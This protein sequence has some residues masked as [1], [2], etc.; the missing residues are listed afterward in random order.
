MKYFTC[1][2]TAALLRKALKAEFANT[3]FGVKSKQYSGGASITVSWVDGPTSEQVKAI[4][5]NFEGSQ[6]D[7]MQDLK[8]N[9]VQELNGEKVSY[10]A[11]YVFTSR[12]H[13]DALVQSAIDHV[14]VQYAGNLSAAG[15]ELTVAKYRNGDFNGVYMCE[16]AQGNNHWSFQSIIRRQL[17]ELA[18]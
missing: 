14:A 3:K 10:G 8:S 4:T 7:G 6:F 9:K 11:D 13:S 5:Q 16:S 18:V 2:E 15:I 1:T 12:D 17:S